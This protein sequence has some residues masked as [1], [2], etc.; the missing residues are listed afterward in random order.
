MRITFAPMVATA[1]GTIIHIPLCILFV[2]VLDFDILG[3]GI[4][5][6]V[7]NLVMLLF[8]MTYAFSKMEV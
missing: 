1:V 6:S 4:A 5:S 2:N 7:K 8:Y 3:L